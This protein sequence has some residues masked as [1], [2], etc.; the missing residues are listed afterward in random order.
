[1]ITL[2]HNQQE[3][4]NCGLGFVTVPENYTLAQVRQGAQ[5]GKAVFV[6]RYTKE[7]ETGLMGEHFSFTVTEKDNR[8]LGSTWMDRQFEKGPKLPSS[9]ET[10]LIARE[11][12][13]KA[14]PDLWPKL[15]NLWVDAHD[16]TIVVA[17]KEITVTGMKY[18][19]F[20]PSEDTYAWVIVGPNRKVITFERGIIWQ[21]GRISE[22]WL[23][24]AWLKEGSR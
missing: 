13:A 7:G 2:N 18:K 8:L 14:E 24:D 16:E 19:C 17:G 10:Q 15:K 6:F 23:H 4:L 22:K 3:A 21:G 9:E 20:I 11:Y 5:D 1:M 12:L